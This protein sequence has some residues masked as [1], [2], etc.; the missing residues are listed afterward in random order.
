MLFATSPKEE[1][2]MTCVLNGK[3]IGISLL[4]L[5]TLVGIASAENFHTV[6]S[7]AVMTKGILGILVSLG[8][9]NWVSATDA[10]YLYNLIAISILIVIAAVSGPRSEAAFCIVIP[11]FA[12][13]FMWMGW[14]KLA[15]PAQTIG[16]YY[17]IGTMAIFGIVLYMKDQDKWTYGTIG[18]GSTMFKLAIFL[19]MFSAALSMVSGFSVANLVPIGS[20]QVAPGTCPV[21]TTCDQF[22]NID[23][24]KTAESYQTAGGL[25]INGALGWIA[26]NAGRFVIILINMAVGVFLFPVILNSIVNGIMPG[27]SGNGAYIAL[28]VGLELVILYIYVTGTVEFLR[29]APGGS[30]L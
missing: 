11:L 15:T 20:T 14:L 26:E 22:N 28:L 21:G 1:K 4:S 18:P 12:G 6:V 3:R 19:A 8:I 29:P 17:L 23:F 25:D 9:E 24:N 13:L 16:L 10:L 30:T 27:I 2:D 7:G 5:I